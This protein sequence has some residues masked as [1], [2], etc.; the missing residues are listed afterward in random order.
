MYRGIF[1][2]VVAT[3]TILTANLLSSYIS[4]LLIS[5][6]FDIKPL[7]FTLIAMGV[8]TIIFYPLFMK[9]EEWLNNF[10]KRFLKAGHSVAGKYLGLIL[11][12]LIG[13][14]M[15]LYFYA[16]MW[17]NIDIFKLLLQGKFF[18]AL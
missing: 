10:S 14:T 2:F 6:R 12:F 9:L 5:H 4:S 11:M 8:I 15:L 17:Y 7:R 1:K 13:L 16:K 18:K 3:L